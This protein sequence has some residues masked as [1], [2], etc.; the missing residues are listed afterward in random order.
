[1]GGKGLTGTWCE[2]VD[3]EEGNVFEQT[4]LQ[5]I[6]I[7]VFQRFRKA[8]KSTYEHLKHLKLL[9]STASNPLLGEVKIHFTA[10]TYDTTT[11]RKHKI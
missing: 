7:V 3:T 11:W 8:L 1:M 5:R 2:R 6:E 9:P 4:T 10:C